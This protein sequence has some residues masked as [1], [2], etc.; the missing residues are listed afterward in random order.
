MSPPD[1]VFVFTIP[2]GLGLCTRDYEHRQVFFKNWD[3]PAISN[4]Q[5]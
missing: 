2:G 1:I 3:A 4:R 5:G